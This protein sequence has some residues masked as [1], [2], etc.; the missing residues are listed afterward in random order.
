[1]SKLAGFHEETFSAMQRIRETT[2]VHF[3]S[4]F[5]PD[6]K[7]WTLQHLRQFHTLFVERF[8]TG[9]GSFL[10]KWRKQLEGADDDILQL[11]AELLYVQQ[12]FTSLTGP[13][14]KLENVNVVLG[15]CAHPPSIPDWA[16]LG[17]KRGI[18][19][20]QSFN[21]H[22]PF[23][24]AWLDEFLIH[25]Q[26][27]PE[28]DRNALLSDP[29]RFADV[30]RKVEFSRGAY[31]P[32]QEAWLYIVFPETFENISSRKDKRRIRDAFYDRLEKGPTENIDSDLLE[33]RK[34]LTSQEG[35]GFHFYQSPIVERWQE[36]NLAGH[37]IELIRQSRSRDKYTDFSPDERTAYKRVHEALRRL[38][39][40]TLDELGG[41][42]D[43]VL[44]L[45][46]GF[47]PASGIRGGKPKDLWFGIYRKENEERFLGNPQI[48]MIVS[49]R[50]IEWG[51]SPLTHPDDF[52]NQDFRRRTREV[53][54]LV[55]EQLPVPQSS[56]AENLAAQLS[57][58]GKWHFRR[59]QRLDPNQSEFRSLADWLSFL[60][61]DEGVR[62]AGG[63]I[64][65]YALDEEIDAIDFVEE[66]QE[67][68]RL[69]RPIMERVIADAPPTTAT[70]HESP[71]TIAASPPPKLAAFGDLLVAFLRELTDAHSGPFQKADPL[72]N[73]MSDVKS[74]LEQFPAVHSRPN[75]LVNISVGQG[76]WA[77]VPWIALLNTKITRSTQEGIY[78]VFL[79]STELDRIFLTLNQGT[80]NLVR[81][82][83]QREAQKQML[84]VAS[85]TR[86]LLSDLAAAGFA[87]D[88]EIELGGGGWLARNYEVGTIAHIDFGVKDVPN[89]ERMN[90]LLEAVLN[91]YDR[92]VDETPT[93]GDTPTDA[94]PTFEPYGVENALS[95]FFLEQP[96][97]E[98]ILTIWAGK[99]NLILQGAPGVGKSFVA[100]RLAYLLLEQKDS[101]RIE[102]VQF[103]QSYSYEDFVQGYR[104]DGK[105]GFTLRDGVFHRFCEKARLSPSRKHVFII[106]EINRGNLS[107]IL[108]ELMLLVEC[109]KRGP[110]WA[111]SL[112]YSQPDEARFFVPE[113]VYLLGMMNTADRSL[114]MV[115]YALRRRFSFTLLEPMFGSDKFRA[116]LIDHGVP[117]AMVD[118][119]VTRMTALNQAIGEDRAN[120]G[121]GYRIGHS[122]F[123]PS[124]DFEYDPGWYRRVIETEIHP[125]LEEYWF[126]E[127][128]KA[129]SWRQQ[130]LQGTP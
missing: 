28:R 14:K 31:Q 61:S 27:L 105:G 24:L 127:P 19:G 51:F 3:D 123:V 10:E 87:L 37:D 38:G 104:P 41:A 34:Q 52:S 109:D 60:R 118:L 13:E 108:G 128:D 96:L 30:V 81:E 57:R 84:D 91:A 76:N 101:G 46:S 65:R 114:S 72:W 97:L 113:N 110:A 6:R 58:S 111:T 93:P 55:L 99:K 62:N 67:M 1:M 15:W 9:E 59:K 50:G 98:R 80:T 47:H 68:A 32:M 23:H 70:H 119:I 120:L 2:L 124:G 7:L 129:D 20:D 4:L 18:A 64:S 107:K 79:I 16:I 78:V 74:R 21:Q 83:G 48:F 106:D 126:D 85:K 40:I 122:F 88:N 130:L 125:L 100:K 25:W 90:E 112:T 117:E 33:I 71:T 53:A 73:A 45:T 8:D 36:A 75:L 35:D 121:P 42:R 22:R 26:E 12:F 102:T 94:P 103:H 86:A 66:V 44:K 17:V 43:Y 11:A 89:D 115:D 56:E 5:S 92:A 49:G 116:F 95:E 77:T 69:F 39:Q 82:L 63:G 54:K 29:W